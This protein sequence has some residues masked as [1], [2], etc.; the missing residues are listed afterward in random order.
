ME[1]ALHRHDA[2]IIGGGLAGLR[3]G[4]E[5][6]RAGADV[7]LLSKVHPLRSHSVAAQGGMNA[8]LGNSPE[9][10]DDSPEKHAFDTVRGSDFLAD[11]DSVAMMCREAPGVVSELEHGGTVFSRFE[12]GRI[13]QRPFGGAGY[14][15]ACYAADRTGHSLLNTLY[16]QVVASGLTIFEE[17]FVTSLVTENGR[18]AG[19]IALDLANGKLHGFAARAALLAT[20]G[21]GRIFGRSTNAII[22]TGDGAALALKAGA[23]LEDMEFVQFHPTTLPGTNILMTE[24]ARGEGGLLLNRTGERFMFRYAPKAM[25]LAPRDIVARSIQTELD[26]GR[27]LDGGYIHLDIRHLGET[28]ITERLPG[29][30]Q[31]AIDF[32]GVDPVERPIPV[33]PGQHYS[34]GGVAVDNDGAS[35]MPG[36]YAAGEA[37]CVS[38][39]GANRLGGNS[40]LETLVFGKRAGTAIVRYIR[41]ASAPSTK[42]VAARLETERASLD[43]LGAGKGGESV[44]AIR[45]ELK[46]AMDASFGI[47]R[48]ERS[49][50]HG[51]ATLEKLRDRFTRAKI[52]KAPGG[53]DFALVRALELEF[54]LA[55]APAVAAGAIQ[56][57]ESRGSHFRRDFPKRNDADFLKHSLVRTENGQLSL[58]Y[59][60]V[61]LGLFP[62]EERRY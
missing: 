60:D 19:C 48:D 46:R 27:G 30:R 56:R 62:V 14:P 8:A 43:V 32:A 58:S 5:L 39:H 41:S 49:M 37:A 25:E 10:K 22:N 54:M 61:R 7:V 45:D 15:R 44:A 33:Q 36:L 1:P 29:I 24:G 50:K 47:F 20:G 2:L 59:K 28:K 3:A 53:F 23:P 16:E 11:Q 18:C 51:L 55:V 6:K 35:P 13:A 42:T 9:G 38:V 40:L 26:E 31:I 12:D 52:S 17:F 34:M 21:Y 4:L 57:Q